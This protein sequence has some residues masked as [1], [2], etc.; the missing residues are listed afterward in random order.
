MSKE[1]VEYRTLKTAV[2]LEECLGW[3]AILD[4]EV[5]GS[6]AMQACHSR[7]MERDPVELVG[8]ELGQ[9]E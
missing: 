3:V 7:Q 9:D 5:A 8:E 1:E 4:E 2:G 6:L